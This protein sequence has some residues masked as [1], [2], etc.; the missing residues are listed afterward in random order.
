MQRQAEGASPQSEV[1]PMLSCA[2]SQP[3]AAAP[4]R[5]QAVGA[6]WGGA[7]PAAVALSR[8]RRSLLPPPAA[9]ASDDGEGEDEGPGPLSSSEDAARLNRLLQQAK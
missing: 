2:L 6:A 3:V 7:A 4:R 1:N 5:A 8:R 9:A